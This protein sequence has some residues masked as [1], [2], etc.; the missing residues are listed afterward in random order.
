M[1]LVPPVAT[2][3]GTGTDFVV[4]GAVTPTLAS[5]ASSRPK[6]SA[7]RSRS[8]SMALGDMTTM[9][10]IMKK[11][12]EGKPFIYVVYEV[13]NNNDTTAEYC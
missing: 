2:A 5:K 10:L 11:E 9:L 4:E 6:T 12:K 3:A 1:P 7:K 8:G 13:P